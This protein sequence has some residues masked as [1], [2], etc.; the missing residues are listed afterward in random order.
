MADLR[1]GKFGANTISFAFLTK[2]LGCKN[3]LGTDTN[4]CWG[5]KI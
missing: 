4:N 2:S 3:N 1:G 5:G